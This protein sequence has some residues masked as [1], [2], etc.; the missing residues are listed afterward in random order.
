M[1]G[2]WEACCEFVREWLV[3]R[4][5]AREACGRG[6][7]GLRR[8]PIETALFTDT[9]SAKRRCEFS[10]VKVIVVECSLTRR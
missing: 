10:S 9:D 4:P 8:V 6:K 2:T 3:V 7:V 5:A 1:V